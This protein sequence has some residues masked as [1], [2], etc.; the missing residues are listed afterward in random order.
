MSLVEPYGA[1]SAPTILP[2]PC[3]VTAQGDGKIVGA[4][5]AP[6]GSTSDI[7]TVVR[8]N[9]DGTLEG[10][11]DGYFDQD[12]GGNYPARQAI[13][14]QP[15]GKIVAV[16]YID[17]GSAYN[18][19]LARFDGQPSLEER[20]YVQQDATYNVTAITDASG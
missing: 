8:F 3:A 5:S 16:G 6:Y 12:G 1:D 13:L 9:L 18:V 15:D 10:S 14:V 17:N 2:S 4:E 20:L 11:A 7:F 19:G